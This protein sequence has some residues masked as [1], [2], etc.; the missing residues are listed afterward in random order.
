LD[1]SIIVRLSF[2]PFWCYLISVSLYFF[3]SLS[4]L[5][6]STYKQE[7]MEESKLLSLL[8][9]DAKIMDGENS[10]N[11]FRRFARFLYQ[12]RYVRIIFLKVLSFCFFLFFLF[13]PK[14]FFE[15][16]FKS[17]YSETAITIPKTLKAMCNFSCCS[18]KRKRYT[19]ADYNANRKNRNITYF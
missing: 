13:I 1:G 2:V 15:S 7:M 6:P 11:I 3:L 9:S 14:L 16:S 10:H 4:K 5:N 17:N 19:K 12:K 18:E 8:W